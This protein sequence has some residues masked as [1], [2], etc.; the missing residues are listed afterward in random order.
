MTSATGM[1]MA[2]MMHNAK[3]RSEVR[4]NRISFRVFRG[5]GDAIRPYVRTTLKAV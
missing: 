2:K 3:N 4:G 5:T 1:A